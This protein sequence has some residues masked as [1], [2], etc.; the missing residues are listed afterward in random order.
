MCNVAVTSWTCG[1][2]TVSVNPALHSVL[3]ETLL[4]T[5]VAGIR[6]LVTECTCSLLSLV[7]SVCFEA[8][9][10]DYS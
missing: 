4:R 7:A 10:S 9:G 5:A 2:A 8:T 6:I 3:Q 1:G